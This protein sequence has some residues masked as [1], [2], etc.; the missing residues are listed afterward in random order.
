[1]YVFI[2]ILEPVKLVGEGEYNLD[3]LK[4]VKVTDSYLG[5]DQDIRDCQNEEPYHNCTTRL[6]MNSILKKCRCLP[7]HLNLL[8]EVQ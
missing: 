2:C 6:Y 1:M 8:N 7:L 3:V 5:L 4:E